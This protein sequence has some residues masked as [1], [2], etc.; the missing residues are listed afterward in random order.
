MSIYRLS[1]TSPPIYRTP[2]L[3]S[4]ELATAAKKA[5]IVM[6]RMTAMMIINVGGESQPVF[7]VDQQ[8]SG[9]R[10]GEYH[11]EMTIQRTTM[12]LIK[13]IKIRA[14]AAVQMKRTFSLLSKPCAPSSHLPQISNLKPF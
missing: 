11:L 4:Q 13:L 7:L 8:M 5:K 6:I 10:G 12:Y 1:I 9:A 3:V 2:L 14:E